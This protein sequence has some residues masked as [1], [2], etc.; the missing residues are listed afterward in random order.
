M[1]WLGAVSFHALRSCSCSYA[2]QNCY[3]SPVPD[4]K[5]IVVGGWKGCSPCV[6]VELS[7]WEGQ[8]TI[9]W[10]ACPLYL[11]DWHSF[12]DHI[13]AGGTAPHVWEEWNLQRLCAQRQHLHQVPLCGW[14]LCSPGNLRLDRRPCQSRSHS[15]R[16]P[17]G[18]PASPPSGLS[19][20]VMTMLNTGKSMICT[21]LAK[22]V[23][24]YVVASEI[25]DMSL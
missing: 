6:V 10:V 15:Q 1:L 16:Q 25:R 7:C 8:A 5:D 19:C 18:K 20:T 12:L 14:L 22:C 2:G 3:L 17:S 24:P 21:P 11:Y 4:K 13:S 9:G 23:L